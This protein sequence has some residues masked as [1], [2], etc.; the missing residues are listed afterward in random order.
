MKKFYRVLAALAACVCACAGNVQGAPRARHVW[1]LIP[2]SSVERREDIGVRAHTNHLIVLSADTPGDTPGGLSPATIRQVYQLPPAGGA[3]L[4]AIVDAYDYPTALK[5]FNI[6][7]RQYGLPVEA[8]R[9]V[10]GQGNRSLEVIY[11][12]GVK[13]EQDGGWN[14]EEALDIEWAHAMAPG[15]KIILVEARSSNAGDLF[16][17]I[18]VA[19]SIPGVREISI[20]WGSSETRREAELDPYFEHAGIVYFAASG[21]TGGRV[22]YPGTSP[23]V[24]SCGGTTLNF[25]G[26]GDFVGEQG[27]S[28]SGGGTSRFELRPVYQDPIQAT[29]GNAR[30]VP[31]FSFDADPDSGVSVYDSTSYDGMAGWMIFGGTSVSAP[32][33]AGI[34]NSAAIAR[35]GFE[36]G[37]FSELGLIYSNMGSGCFRDISEGSAGA[38]ECQPGWDFVT[39]LGSALSLAGK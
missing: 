8:S 1:H 30:G 6:F 21:D 38:F 4:I 31:D 22:I 11:A 10:T 5:D 19:S 20:S 24:V 16:A 26:N 13:P 3:G 25:D 33:L 32:A 23:R 29:V 34:V 14:E 36:P 18:S 35:G 27:W 12:A 17:A 37:S 7:S 9:D 39:G 2:D 28:G 15:A